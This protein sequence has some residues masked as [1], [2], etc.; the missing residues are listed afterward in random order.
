MC[1]PSAAPQG[2]GAPDIELSPQSV[3]AGVAAYRQFDRDYDSDEEMVHAVYLAIRRYQS[4]GS[5]R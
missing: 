3:Q 5:S 2:D 4:S 1:I